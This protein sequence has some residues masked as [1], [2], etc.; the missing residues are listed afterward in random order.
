MGKMTSREAGADEH[1]SQA[2][3]PQCNWNQYGSLS[4]SF[5]QT[6]RSCGRAAPCY[7]PMR[8]ECRDVATKVDDKSISSKAN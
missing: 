8:L 6:Y 5:G 2:L 4:F 3:S 7:V 1:H